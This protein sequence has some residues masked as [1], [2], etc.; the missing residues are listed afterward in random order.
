MR[1]QSFGD[2]F[3]IPYEFY[4]DKYIL[5][6]IWNDYVIWKWYIQLFVLGFLHIVGHIRQHGSIHCFID[7]EYQMNT[8]F[9]ECS[10][11]KICEPYL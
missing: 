11:A 4:D 1:F 3:V 9:C 10:V 7:M 6:V 5:L 8:L 2:G